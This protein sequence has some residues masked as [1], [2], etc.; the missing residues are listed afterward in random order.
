MTKSK[1]VTFKKIHSES[2]YSSL[3]KKHDKDA[4]DFWT[5]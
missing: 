2:E 5:D 4:F 3:Q 1:N